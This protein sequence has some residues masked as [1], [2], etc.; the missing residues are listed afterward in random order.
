V[1]APAATSSRIARRFPILSPLRH[2][3]FRF[4][5]AGMSVSLL[6]DG[7]TTIALAWQ[8]YEIS[9][10]PTALALIGVAQTVP[11]VVLLLVSGAVSDRFERRKVLIAADAVRMLAMCALGVLAVT[12][13]I[14]IWHM[15]LIAAAYGAGSAFFGP[16][17]DAVVP[18][19]VPEA[20]LPQANSLDQFVRP[21]LGDGARPNHVE[22]VDN[23]KGSVVYASL[24][25]VDDGGPGGVASS[26]IAIIDRDARRGERRMVGDFFTH[27]REAHGL[28]TNPE[29]TLLY[30]AHEQDELPGTPNAGQTVCSA[31]DVSDPLRPG[32]IAQIPLGSLVLPSGPLRNKKSINLVYVR[33]GTPGQTA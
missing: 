18:D 1:G 30:V 5:W 17:F 8:A 21:A 2:R 28:W 12:G 31:F 16:A 10:V 22:F 24:A 32:F 19:L 6:G 3:D 25:R 23:D 4:L 11:H 20:E 14:Q 27:G 26:R 15:M 33:P 7:I 29:N 13:T 9:N